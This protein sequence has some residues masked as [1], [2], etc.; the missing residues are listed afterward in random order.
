MN[1]T[2]LIVLMTIAVFI[3]LGSITMLFFGGIPPWPV[4]LCFAVSHITFC[5]IVARVKPYAGPYLKPM[6]EPTPD[7]WPH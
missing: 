2:R 5:L 3:V 7:D 6:A 4:I 1:R